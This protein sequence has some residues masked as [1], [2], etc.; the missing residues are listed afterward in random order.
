MRP[1]YLLALGFG[2][3]ALAALVDLIWRRDWPLFR[4]DEPTQPPVPA[5]NY[6]MRD[7]N[8][9]EWSAPAAK[10]FQADPR[11]ASDHQVTVVPFVHGR[12]QRTH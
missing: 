8:P 9:R 7:V 5:P 11:R 1:E 6:Y 2:F 3:L 10:G 4:E 12:S